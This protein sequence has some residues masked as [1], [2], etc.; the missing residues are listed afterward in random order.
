MTRYPDLSPYA[1]G[2]SAAR[3]PSILNVGWL[4]RGAPFERGDVPPA[5][6]STLARLCAD[7]VQRTRGFHPCELCRSPTVGVRFL[8]DGRE[9]VLGSAEIRVAGSGGIIYA[10]PNLILH[11]VTEHRYLPPREFLDALAKA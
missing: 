3:D 4:G 9:I 1:Y 5:L 6:V 2:E 7:P 8:H 11:Y 10:A